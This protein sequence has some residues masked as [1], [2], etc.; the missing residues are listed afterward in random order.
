MELLDVHVEQ[1]H[2]MQRQ[3]LQ[4]APPADHREIR[5]QA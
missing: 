2:F 3:S 4:H 5:D 1:C